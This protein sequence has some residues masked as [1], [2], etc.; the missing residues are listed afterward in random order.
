MP[1]RSRAGLG[2][3]ALCLVAGATSAYA[4]EGEPFVPVLETSTA[5]LQCDGTTK[6]YVVNGFVDDETASTPTWGPEEPAS[7]TTGA[8][9]GK[10]D[11]AFFS[12]TRPRTPY[13]LTIAGPI[14]GNVDSVTIT[15]HTADAGQSRLDGAPLSFDVRAV[16]DGQSLFGVTSNTSTTGEVV[17]S[18]ADVTVTTTPVGTGATGGVRAV[19]FTITNL[20]LLLEGDT[21]EHE[22]L[23]DIADSG[24]DLALDNHAWVWGAAEAPSSVVANPEAPAAVTVKATDRSRRKPV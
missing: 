10:A 6:E 13:Q 14:S 24:A 16:L 21:G 2:A 9:C 3:A 4:V 20:G 8:G 11:E 22:L 17:N 19:S 12:G 18:P 23:V 7:V 5:Y 15:L 1:V